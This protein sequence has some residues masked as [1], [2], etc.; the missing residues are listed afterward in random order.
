[1][2]SAVD[3]M[4]RVEPAHSTCSTDRRCID[5]SRSALEIARDRCRPAHFCHTQSGYDVKPESRQ[6]RNVAAL[7]FWSKETARAR[8]ARTHDG[9]DAQ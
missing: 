5:R 8:Q 3:A 7:S 4:M 2:K 1:M 9:T 6:M